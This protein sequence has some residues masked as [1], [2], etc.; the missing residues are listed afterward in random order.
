MIQQKKET[1][2]IIDDEVESTDLLKKYIEGNGYHV[3]TA[4]DGVEALDVMEKN[5]IGIAFCDVVMPNMDGLEFL[6]KVR[7][8]NVKVQIIMVTGNPSSYNCVESLA[9]GVCEYL[10]KPVPREAIMESIHRAERNLKERH[11][12][13]ERGLKKAS[14]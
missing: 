5:D 12:M 8:I 14:S 4:H 2:L 13:F 11:D 3:L 7:E 6:K 1:V 10:V 9:N